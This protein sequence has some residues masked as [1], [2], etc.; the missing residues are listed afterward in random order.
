MDRPK[1]HPGSTRGV[2]ARAAW[3]AV[4]VHLFTAL[5]AVCALRAILALWD[6]AWEV[7]F[8]WL[9][10]ALVIDGIDGTF[11][12]MARVGE[13]LPRFSGERLD[14]VVDYVT[15]VLVP[16]LALLKAGYLH[17]EP[18][19]VLAS[20]ILLSSLYHFCDTESKTEDHCFVGFPAI[21]NIVAFYIFA[22]ALPPWA[23][24]VVVTGCVLLTFVP[25][26]WTHP[27]RTVA[28]WPVTA[29]A[30]ALWSVAALFIVCTGFPATPLWA[31]ML[32]LVGIYGV[33]LT[34]VHTHRS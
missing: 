24:G 8:A 13:R 14:L 26:A 25:L 10:V 30:T 19:V 1:G 21:W 31:G 28:L 2:S 18:G 7:C 4:L 3:P 34:L 12:R 15:Y 22:F 20:L 6:G 11:A 17:G 33:I 29:V 32:V 27:L 23:A 16:T 9:G 5:G